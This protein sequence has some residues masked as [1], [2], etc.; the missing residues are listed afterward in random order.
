MG[1]GHRIYKNYD[2]RAK[3]VKTIADEVFGITGKEP[4]VDIAVELERIALT[5]EYFITKKLYP[6]VDFYSGVIYKA[7]GIPTEM[8]TI[9]FTIPRLAGWLAHWYEFLDDP[10]N[11]IVRP[12]QIYKGEKK[13]DFVPMAM[14]QQL[15]KEDIDYK[16]DVTDTRREASIKYNKNTV[17]R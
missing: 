12:R 3:I 16:A 15:V 14:R 7:L 9:M 5:D 17:Q 4:L 13:R 2:P 8:F 10:H 6:N 11:K 1:F